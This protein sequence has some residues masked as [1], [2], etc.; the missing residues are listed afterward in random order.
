MSDL[1]SRQAA[2]DALGRIGSLDTYADREYATEIFMN[3]PSAQP[4]E[5][6]KQGEWDMFE[7]ITTA[8]YG[9][10]YY[11]KEEN[12]MAYSRK[13]H[14]TMTVHDAILEFIREIGE[15]M[16]DLIDRAAAID[17]LKRGRENDGSSNI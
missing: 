13:S 14:K 3:L 2:I 1:I 6:R 9:K 17:A 15:G 4:I 11:F 7:L 16:S 10:Q 5:C 8:W 12:G